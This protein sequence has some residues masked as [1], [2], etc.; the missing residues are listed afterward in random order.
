MGKR[1]TL[2]LNEGQREH[3]HRLSASL[4]WRSELPTWLLIIAIYG[5]WFTTLMFWQTLGLLPATLLLIWFTAWYMSLQHEL[6]HGHPTRIAW[7]NALFGAMPLA[8]WYPYGLY[9]DS[10][11]AHHRHDSLTVPVDDPESYYFTRESW[12]RFS[13]WQKRVIHARN[14]FVG[15]LLL[16]PLL[17]IL[18][19]L[20]GAA[21]AFRH[22]RWRAMG[23]WL[24]HGLLLAGLFAWM[25]G[26]GF[27]PVWF[28]L[29]VS[30]P[31]LALTKVR[32]FLEHR[33]ADDPLARSAINEAGVFWRVLFLNLNYHSVHHDLPGI[34]WY[35]LKTIY[36][37]GREAYQQ[38]NHGFLVKGSGEWL[39]RYWG[40]PVDVTVHPGVKR[41]EEHE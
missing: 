31:A 26:V 30:Y 2:Y 15:R 12:A 4:L 40:R 20:G 35:G 36:L 25:I 41:G 1:S 24:T 16:A 38:R 9:R 37:H 27:S 22:L 13:P 21:G 18:Q 23:M 5:G 10:H 19:T 8:V 11:L 3:I 32:S 34:P 7:L 39:R 29:A 28:V 6:I 33:V 17:D 14:T